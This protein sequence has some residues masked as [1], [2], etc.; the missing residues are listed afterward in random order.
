MNTPMR[1]GS[2]PLT[3]TRE[4][5]INQ[6]NFLDYAEGKGFGDL[7]F[8][9]DPETGLRAIV[10]IHNTKLG[11]ALGGSRLKAYPTPFEA[12]YDAMRLARAMSYKAALADLPLGGGKSVLMEPKTPIDR[13]SYFKSFGAFV[14]TLNGRYIAAVDI[15]TTCEDMDTMSEVT[16]Y[17]SCLSRDNGE[18]SPYTAYGVRRGIEAAVAFKLG[19]KNLQ[20]IH[21]AI[22]GAGK[23]GSFLAGELHALGAK[24]SVADVNPKAVQTLVERYGVKPVALDLIHRLP[25]DVFAPCALGAILSERSLSELQAPIVAGGANNQLAHAE[26]GL[27]LYQRNILYAPDYVINAGGLI[28]CAHQYNPHLAGTVKEQIE[29]LYEVLLAIFER[30]EKE[31]QPTNVIADRMAEEKIA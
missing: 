21:V 20:G 29:R 31:K 19:K 10:A 9:V 16:P 7:H 30:S 28:H 23:V 25:C 18:P 17:V 1:M 6:D 3:S 12:L 4:I 8:K 26:Q 22:Q 13:T 11:P 15:G 24:I 27:Q 2:I 5:S 14:H